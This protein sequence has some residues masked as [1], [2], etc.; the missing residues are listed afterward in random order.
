[1]PSRSHHKLPTP[2]PPESAPYGQP[3]ESLLVDEQKELVKLLL[4]AL[5]ARDREILLRFYVSEQSPEQIC[6]EMGITDTQFRLIKSRAKVKFAQLI[7]NP[8][9]RRRGPGKARLSRSGAGSDV[10]PAIPIV[11]H[12]IAVFGDEH[13]A[14]HWLQTPLALLGDRTPAQVLSRGDIHAVDAILTRIEHNIPS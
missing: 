1:M 6:A 9:R 14:S 13:K 8:P 11:A 5:S 10:G 4:G 2:P 3:A 12:A 7:R